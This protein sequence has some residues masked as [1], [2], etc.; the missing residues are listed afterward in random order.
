VEVPA[1][2][3]G[4]STSSEDGSKPEPRKSSSSAILRK[5]S[6]KRSSVTDSI[7]LPPDSAM[8]DVP[9]DDKEEMLT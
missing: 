2:G 3:S 5:L 7:E 6:G 8:M 9:G 4:D 1:L